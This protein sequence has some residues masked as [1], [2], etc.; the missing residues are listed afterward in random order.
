MEIK[1]KEI[2]IATL[3][4]RSI[5]NEEKILYIKDLLIENNIDIL[6]LQ[7]THANEEEKNKYIQKHL[8][9]YR[10][11][12]SY[13]D[14]ASK[15]VGIL[16]SKTLDIDNIV[17]EIIEKN[18]IIT[19][20]II[21]KNYEI[22]LI[23]IYSPN[24][25]EEQSQI[26]E[27]MYN[28]CFLKKN[29]I[30]AGDFNY[31]KNDSIERDP[32]K[33]S[34][35]I[36]IKEWNDLYKINNIAEA[37][38]NNL[39]N[40]Y[41]RTWTNNTQSARLDRIYHSNN[42]NVKYEKIIPTPS[43][44]KLVIAILMIDAGTKK[45]IR[46]KLNNT[47]L[48]DEIT[49]L[50]IHE[51]CHRIKEYFDNKSYHWYNTF[52]RNIQHICKRNSK[53]IN[54]EKTKI[55]EDNLKCIYEISLIEANKQ[56]QDDQDR[57]AAAEKT[58]KGYY[59]EKI[60][61]MENK[62][63]KIKT[64]F[65]KTPTKLLLQNALKEQSERDI[66]YIYYKNEKVDNKVKIEA[67]FKEFYTDIL[68][69]AYN[70]KELENY[71]ILIPTINN[72]KI[73]EEINEP[74]N[75]TEFQSVIQGMD[76]SAPGE[77]GLTI[78]FFK[79][80]FNKFA[81][82]FI[83]MV[84]NNIIPPKIKNSTITLIPKNNSQKKTT[85]D[86]RPI[87]ITNFEYRIITK[88]LCERIKNINTFIFSEVQTCSIENRKIHHTI[89]LTR[90]IITDANI[91]N[92]PLN[93]VAIDQRKAFDKISHNY[94]FKVLKK[95]GI[96][97][98]ILS[99]IET[100]Y[101]GSYTKI[102]INGNYSEDI[103]IRN[104]IK[105]GCPLSMWL[106]ILAIEQLF[107]KIKANEKITGYRLN[108]LDKQEI[109]CR[110]Y[111]DDVTM[112][113]KDHNSILETFNEFEIWGEFSGA[114]IN[115]DKTKI[116]KINC[117][118]TQELD[119]LVVDEMEI[120]GIIFDKNGISKKC[121]KISI[122]NLSKSIMMWT[123]IKLDLFQKVTAIKTFM[124]SKIWYV[125]NFTTASNNQIKNINTIIYNYLW[126]GKRD[127]IKRKTMILSTEDGGV[128]MI[129]I[130][131]RIAAMHVKY[132]MEIIAYN[133]KIEYQYP[134]KWFKFLI[135]QS[136]KNFNNIPIE[137]KK[138]EPLFFIQV[139]KSYKIYT[140]LLKT[141]NNLLQ[142]L[143]E[144][145]SLLRNIYN[146]IL[147]N[148]AERPKIEQDG[149][150]PKKNWKKTYNNIVHTNLNSQLQSINYKVAHNALP[151]NDKFKDSYKK[152]YLCKRNNE[153]VL[154]LFTQCHITR[155]INKKII[156]RDLNIDN[157][158]FHENI[159]DQEIKKISTIK[160]SIWLT[161]N[162]IKYNNP[163]SEYEKIIYEYYNVLD[164]YI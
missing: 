163:N 66:N 126:N 130:Q 39:V 140:D 62:N 79:K 40:P 7:E 135:R 35:K 132:M 73:I 48:N 131:T 143:Y 159:N 119:K 55:V 92:K 83:E 147:T 38:F 164:N 144:K 42:L 100:L 99:L 15:G 29:I 31:V 162:K 3:N 52:I 101:N 91:K 17:T 75:Y 8:R 121:M 124:L 82:Y 151:T 138:D 20:K 127:F 98:R 34:N 53:R 161:R 85:N 18:R 139:E 116:L 149:R 115:R 142:K 68:S 27:L 36:Q 61:F 90:D 6:F 19:T 111:A 63:R 152:C 80:F 47:I 94:I 120:L 123:N 95:I 81:T 14:N 153:N 21:I 72:E 102:D 154:H 106:Y 93:I 105:Q 41:S 107:L 58:I 109:K 10:Y 103:I 137:N 44:H 71:E 104:G 43:D 65:A 114:E 23:N 60:K 28:T 128:D 108:I 54:K 64:E 76:E 46:W 118:V 9:S 96:G 157:I 86:Y 97:Q 57:K 112:M 32:P 150:F 117:E 113:V 148:V 125:M 77:N 2:K 122:E 133:G 67:I 70:N 26:I 11:I 16:I 25:Y 88:I 134:L 51:E 155:T 24:T 160:L 49:T 4:I 129:C 37:K 56:T 30:L 45:K 12:F 74:F 13:S 59:N 136:L 5:Y 78:A 110:A 1:N 50:E 69:Q 33:R 146:I 141:N 158:L 156:G 89:H 87:S 145:N 22:N 84:N